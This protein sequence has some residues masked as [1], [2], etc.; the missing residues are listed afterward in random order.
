MKSLF[1]MF[2]FLGLIPRAVADPWDG[3]N[4]PNRFASG[5]DYQ[6]QNLPLKGDV[7]G[8]RVPW[9]ESYWP[10]NQGSINIR[11]NAPGKPGFDYHSPSKEELMNMSPSEIAQL[12]PTEKYDLYRGRY[13][14]PLKN[15]IA[16]SEA[17]RNAPDWAGICDGWSASAIQLREPKAVT[18]INPDG[19]AIP[20]GAS[21]VKG[22]ISY[23]A[24][25]QNLQS[26]VI[27]R[28][29]P[30]G[31]S[32]G[33]ANCQDIN[34]GAFHVILANELG[35]RKTAFPADIDPGKQ[36]WNQPIIGYEFKV[37]G[38]AH[39]DFSE[40][41][42]RIHSR[43]IYVDELDNS[44]FEPVTGTPLWKS[45]VQESDYIL[46]LDGSGRIVGGS[47]LTKYIHPDVFWKPT[48]N[49]EFSGEYSQ[50][51]E[52]YE[53]IPFRSEIIK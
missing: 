30:F 15:Y 24:A 52:L 44:S 43:L 40:N 33:F 21:D 32:L 47:W 29:C 23:T 48:T 39:S 45:A 19:I 27:G 28:Y 38:S 26:I 31:L 17:N 22:L 8:A 9:S 7:D 1:L 10:R 51:P 35:I 16:S 34:P 37:L 3:Y 11:W 41:A 20:F 53:P 49:I 6:F 18:R 42:L 14:Y 25:R 2:T 46:E 4:D 12:S 50:L 36:A 13:D 5:Y